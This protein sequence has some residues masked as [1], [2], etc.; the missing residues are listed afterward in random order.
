MSSNLAKIEK[1]VPKK[2]SDP[3]ALMITTLGVSVI[4]AAG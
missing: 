1:V 3:K 2:T 4:G